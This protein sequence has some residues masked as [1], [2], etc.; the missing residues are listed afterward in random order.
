MAM[1]HVRTEHDM[2][3][4]IR[5]RSF[6]SPVVLSIRYP[7]GPMNMTCEIPKANRRDPF[8]LYVNDLDIRKP[9]CRL[10]CSRGLQKKKKKRR[11]VLDEQHNEIFILDA[12]F[13]KHN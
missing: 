8:C 10:I 1:K 2:L 6:C 9:L 7:I 12:F 13:G 11:N 5:I 4:A 3:D